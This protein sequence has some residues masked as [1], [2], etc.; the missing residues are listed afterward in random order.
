MSEGFAS[1]VEQSQ[2]FNI[3]EK[4]EPIIENQNLPYS[5]NIELFTVTFPSM[6]LKVGINRRGHN[7]NAPPVVEEKFKFIFWTSVKIANQIFDLHVSI[8]TLNA[9]TN[10]DF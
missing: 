4:C 6:C 2:S 10:S 7:P 9:H 3:Y 8:H 5:F 1:V